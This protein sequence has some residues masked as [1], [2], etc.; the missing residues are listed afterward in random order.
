MFLPLIL[1]LLQSPTLAKQ[2]ETI[3]YPNGLIFETVGNVLLV[4]QDL[5]FEL[6][7]VTP[8]PDTS[9]FVPAR[10]EWC[11]FKESDIELL[12]ESTEQFR[13]HLMLLFHLFM[14][15][16]ENVRDI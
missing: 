12:A 4:Q 5:T 8:V 7:L 14:G 2:D 1:A 15:S 13:K 10:S 16:A 6:Q 11:E 3:L 9:T